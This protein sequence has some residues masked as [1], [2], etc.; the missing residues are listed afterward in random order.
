MRGMCGEGVPDWGFP[1][2]CCGRPPGGPR[3][4][5]MCGEPLRVALLLAEP[6]GSWVCGKEG[7]EN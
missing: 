4:E 3:F 6:L 2:C 1:G 7:E 5:L